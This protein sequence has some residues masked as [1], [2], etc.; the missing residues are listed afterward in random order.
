MTPR[1][2]AHHHVWDLAARDQPWISG[3]AM[4]P[5]RRSFGFDDLAPEAAAA[6]APPPTAVGRPSGEHTGEVAALYR[7]A[8]DGSGRSGGGDSA[9]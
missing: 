1:I 9:G 3:E 6:Q 2:D 5:L 7:K 8:A 4:A